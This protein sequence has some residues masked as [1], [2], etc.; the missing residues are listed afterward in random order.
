[1]EVEP[2]KHK[3]QCALREIAM[4]D[5]ALD[6]DSDLVIAV[7]GMEMRRRMLPREMPITMPR[8][9]DISGTAISYFSSDFS[10]TA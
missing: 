8:N 10:S 1:M 4:H 2:L 5:T 6:T 7:H 3:P 9:L